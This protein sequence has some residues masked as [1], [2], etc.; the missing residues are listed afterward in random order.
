M[1]KNI[2]SS[3]GSTY[4]AVASGIESVNTGVKTAAAQPEGVSGVKDSFQITAQTKGDPV[5]LS[6]ASNPGYV[7]SPSTYVMNFAAT[8]KPASGLI[9]ND[10]LIKSLSNENLDLFKQTSDLSKNVQSSLEDSSAALTASEKK[11]D[12]QEEVRDKQKEIKELQEKLR[13]IEESKR[14]WENIGNFFGSDSGAERIDSIAIQETT[15][16]HNTQKEKSTYNEIL[17]NIKG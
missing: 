11:K 2:S 6:I 5:N 17:K 14:I 13:E 16:Q 9:D 10:Q 4:S 1:P 8:G 12:L 7:D 3:V 15:S